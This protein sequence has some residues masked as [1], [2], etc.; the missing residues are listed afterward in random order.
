V[1]KTPEIYVRKGA[2][3]PTPL[4][5]KLGI[6]AGQR[7]LIVGR[8]DADFVAS[9]RAAGADVSTR[10]RRDNDVI[11]VAASDRD[12]LWQLGPLQDSMKRDGAIWTIR[13]KGM[14][15]ITERDVMEAAKVAGLVDVKVARFSE[16]HTAEKLVIPV[17]Q[18]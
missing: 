16:T 13:P 8:L 4:L 18:R 7:I 6:K 2:S 15:S 14:K 17:A 3:A 10:K 5:D 12:A 11:F 1:P 9:L